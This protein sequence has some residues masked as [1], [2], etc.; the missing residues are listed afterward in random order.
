MKDVVIMPFGVALMKEG[1]VIMEFPTEQE[2]YEYK[3]ELEDSDNE[4]RTD[5]KC[6]YK[7]E[8]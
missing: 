2:A 5:Q 3:R 7:N 6:G 8:S 4:N 1:R